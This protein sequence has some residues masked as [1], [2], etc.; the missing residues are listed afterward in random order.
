MTGR[1]VL[2]AALVLVV[3]LDIGLVWW[4]RQ[5]SPSS[6]TSMPDITQTD[7]LKAERLIQWNSQAAASMASPELQSVVA[8]IYDRH[9]GTVPPGGSPV[10]GAVLS[11]EQRDDL[12]AATVGFLK[13]YSGGDPGEFLAY[14]GSRRQELSGPRVRQI[15]TL[16][17][18]EGGRT[19][20][21]VN[22][23]SDQDTYKVLWQLLKV[24]SH[25]DAIVAESCCIRVFD[26]GSLS[27]DNLRDTGA[28]A[29][30]EN[31]VWHS[32][33][34]I[35]PNFTPINQ[36]TLEAAY[37]GAQKSVLVADATIIV[38]HDAALLK[39]KAPY[40]VRLWFNPACKQWQPMLLV[41]LRSFEG[42]PTQL[43]F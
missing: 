13:S 19:E 9:C 40:L 38:Q 16:L 43:L 15:R 5:R 32:M 35:S 8:G 27:V 41:Q 28:L 23:L 7:E 42:A 12:I 10:D 14:M 1:K 29:K 36:Q 18:E 6:A 3:P 37:N 20:Q 30:D 31:R 2:I 39:Q 26:S 25:W 17:S 33:R 4:F 22:R 21:E 24:N 11:T 34:S